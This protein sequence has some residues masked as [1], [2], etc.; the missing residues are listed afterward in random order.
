M[1]SRNCCESVV[2]AAAAAGIGRLRSPSELGPNSF[3]GHLEPDWWIGFVGR[4]GRWAGSVNAPPPF[5]PSPQFP[6]LL[7]MTRELLYVNES[8]PSPSARN[9]TYCFIRSHDFAHRIL[10]IELE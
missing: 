4:T 2:V 8:V 1:R 7:L 6:I 3:R 5:S 10:A 9:F